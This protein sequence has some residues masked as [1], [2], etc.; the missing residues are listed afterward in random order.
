MAS[1]NRDAASRPIGPHYKVS[2]VAWL[3]DK[4]PRWVKNKI[5]DGVL[6]GYRCDGDIL[7]SVKSINAYLDM[8]RITGDLESGE[9]GDEEEYDSPK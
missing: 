7:V 1:S 6:D 4:S 8:V 9:V 3:L 2:R 5:K